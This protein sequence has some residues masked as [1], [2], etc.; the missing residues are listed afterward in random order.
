[1]AISG[2]VIKLSSK[3]CG[4]SGIPVFKR[5][6]RTVDKAR[7]YMGDDIKI[8]ASGGIFSSMDALNALHAGANTVQ[9]YTGM[10][11]KGPGL[12]KSINKGLM[13]ERSLVKTTVSS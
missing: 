4:V 12:I 10:I 6:L 1:M 11:Y 2:N 8:N 13:N 9:V 3:T 7:N 5:M